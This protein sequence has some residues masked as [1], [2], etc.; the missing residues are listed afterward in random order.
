MLNVFYRHAHPTEGYINLENDKLNGR[1]RLRCHWPYDL[2]IDQWIDIDN[3]F[4]AK[5]FA[6]KIAR[7][8]RKKMVIIRGRDWRR[9]TFKVLTGK[10]IEMD[11][12]G[13]AKGAPQEFCFSVPALPSNLMPREC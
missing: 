11:L 3:D 9:V 10:L 7:L 12:V 2:S 1:V 8:A 5:E 13:G 4:S 6:R